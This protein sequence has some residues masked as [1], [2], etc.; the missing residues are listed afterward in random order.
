MSEAW[1][2][3]SESAIRTAAGRPSGKNQLRLPKAELVEQVSDPKDVLFQALR[4]ASGYSG[5]KLKNLREGRL[6]HRV[7]ELIEDPGILRKLSAFQRL[8]NDLAAELS[9]RGWL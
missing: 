2:L 5:R 3:L 6:R 7:A 1:L 4:D 8:E 9:L